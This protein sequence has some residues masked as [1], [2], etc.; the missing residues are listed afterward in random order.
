MAKVESEEIDRAL[1]TIV[2]EVNEIK[3]AIEE[4][5]STDEIIRN[6]AEIRSDSRRGLGDALVVAKDEV[7]KLHSL[8]HTFKPKL[9]AIHQACNR[10]DDANKTSK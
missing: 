2:D 9:E 8:L 10:I 4:N 3:F 7:G 1:K 5:K 6:L